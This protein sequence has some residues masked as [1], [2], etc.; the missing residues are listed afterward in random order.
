MK[1][2]I[3]SLI[4]SS[5]FLLVGCETIQESIQDTFQ[6]GSTEN[7]DVLNIELYDAQGNLITG[8][9]FSTGAIVNDVQ[10]VRYISVSFSIKNEGNV[11]LG[12]KVDIQAP[13]PI[14]VGVKEYVSR[15]GGQTTCEDTIDGRLHCVLN[16]PKGILPNQKWGLH[17]GLVDIEKIGY[18][19]HTLSADATAQYKDEAGQIK[20]ISA[21]S[22]KIIN[23]QPDPITAGIS[24]DIGT[25]SSTPPPPCT[26]ECP[27]GMILSGDKCLGDPISNEPT[28]MGGWLDTLKENQV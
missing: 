1:K 3:L 24:V 26:F 18:G 12:A 15:Q 21:S 27:K 10:D 13:D 16:A 4:I 20:Y 5:L 7:D 25:S 17:S 22:S 2:I 19:S 6:G 9:I 23:I 14:I 8:S 28:N 11:N